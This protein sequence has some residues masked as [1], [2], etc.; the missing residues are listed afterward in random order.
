MAARLFGMAADERIDALAREILERPRYKDLRADP[1]DF[2]KA[3]LQQLR[4]LQDTL[5][6]LHLT[7]PPL[8]WTL[9]IGLS[10]VCIALFAHFFWTM[11]ALF[12]IAPTPPAAAEVLRERDFAV[13]AEALAERGEHLEAA[14][15]ILLAT[16]KLLARHKTIALLPDDTNRVVRDKLA[17]SALPE[18]LRVRLAALITETEQLWF[19]AG[20]VPRA[21]G[22]ALYRRWC[23]V[24][25][26]L[27][28]VIA[29]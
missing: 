7:N 5:L 2:V 9:L 13:E 29:R 3:L 20:V 18:P 15:R 14:H 8:Y 11:R 6:T 16:L 25:D 24:R 1:S 10:L 21:I 23:A 12:R 28:K 17:A 27:A 4:A 26:E 19:G 22:A